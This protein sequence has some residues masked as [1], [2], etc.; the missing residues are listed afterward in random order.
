[1]LSKPAKI[2][3]CI[4]DVTVFPTAGSY[5]VLDG[6]SVGECL[7][8]CDDWDEADFRWPNPIREWRESRAT[9]CNVHITGRTFQFRCGARCAR[10]RVEWIGD[11]EPSE[12]SK[13]WLY[14]KE[15]NLQ[16]GELR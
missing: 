9:A 13:G 5:V 12:S 8:P 11:G 1:M 15:E 16:Y 3:G 4:A 7:L 2:D 6:R 10:C 14:V